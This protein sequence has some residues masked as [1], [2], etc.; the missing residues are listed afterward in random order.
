V[1]Q[2]VRILSVVAAVTLVAAITVSL[3]ARQGSPGS[4][5]TPPLSTPVLPTASLDLDPVID[6]DRFWAMWLEPIG[7]DLTFDADSLADSVRQADVVVVAKLTDVYVGEYWRTVDDE[8]AVPLVYGR[9]EIGDLLKGELRSRLAGSVEVQLGQLE[10]EA[11]IEIPNLRM[12]MPTHDNLWFLMYGPNWGVRTLEPQVSAEIAAYEYFLG[13]EYQGLIRG[14]NGQVRLIGDEELES[15][16]GP[17]HFP[18]YLDGTDFDSLVTQVRFLA[19]TTEA[20]RNAPHG[21]A[22]Q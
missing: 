20:E 16:Y 6:S 9:L 2:L 13:N 8:P 10:G 18:L 1:N 17:A 21:F 22:A 19:S 4:D 12:I 5:P 7:Y 11:E 15:A 14:I 3:P